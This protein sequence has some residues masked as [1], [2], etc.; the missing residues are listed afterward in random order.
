MS[1]ASSLSLAGSLATVSVLP[2]HHV[3]IHKVAHHVYTTSNRCWLANWRYHCWAYRRHGPSPSKHVLCHGKSI[4]PRS[5]TIL[6]TKRCPS[7]IATLPPQYG[8]YSAFVGTITYCVRHSMKCILTYPNLPP[9]VRHVQGY[10]YW[11]GRSH[12]SY[13]LSNN[14][15]R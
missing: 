14:H 3:V 1:C 11:P 10:F 13:G 4:S 7:Q 9:V 6:V 5:V 2:S 8:L 12:V 15:I